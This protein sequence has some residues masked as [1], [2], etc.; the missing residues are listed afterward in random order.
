M[1]CRIKF[2]I[3]IPSFNAEKFIKQA[4]QSVYDQTYKNYEI[5]VVDD[6]SKDNTAK[7]IG[8]IKNSS[9]KFIQSSNKGVSVARNIGLKNATGDYIVFL[10]SD[11]YIEP[12]T[13]ET[14]ANKLRRKPY[15]GVFVGMFNTVKDEEGVSGCYSE[16]LNKRYI[17]NKQNSQ[18]LDYFYKVRLIFTVWRFIVRRD[19]IENNNLY[20]EEGL[21]H[22]DEDW[23]TR[24]L[25]LIDD[26]SLIEIPFYNYRIHKNSI[27]RRQDKQHLRLRYD[28]RYKIAMK[29]VDMAD[30]YVEQY[31]K[32]FLYRCAY[33]N[34]QQIYRELKKQANPFPPIQRRKHK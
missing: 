27:M 5:I 13:L 20:F 1:E 30:D 7:I 11:D 32:D 14:I 3:I 21:L 33:K 2:S 24:M 22:E 29:F 17:N 16:Y 25:L 34:I 15:I 8:Q 23:V 9:L 31:K 12:W 10:D 6:G 18:V 4:I 26:F 28:S 19:I